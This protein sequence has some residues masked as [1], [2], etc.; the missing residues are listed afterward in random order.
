MA[1]KARC[2]VVI[3]TFNGAHLLSTCLK[4][5]FSH[6]PTTYEWQVI[7]V[8][9]ASSDGT[10]ERFS[11]YHERLTMV[12]LE[13]NQ[14]FARACNEGARVAGDAEHL[15]FLNNDTVPL[16][17]WLDALVD[18]LEANSRAAAVGAKL[19]YPDG[20]VQHAGV[21][22]GRDRWPH[23][24]Y[25]GLPGEHPAVNRAKRVV[26]ATAACLLV[27]RDA[28]ER[29]NGFDDAFLNGYEDVDFC[30]RLGEEGHEVRYC[31]RSVLYHLESVTRW[32]EDADRHDERNSRLYAERWHDRI[33]PDDFGH[34]LDDGL[35]EV[36]YGNRFPIRLSV[37]P[38]LAS[39][40]RET[41]EEGDRLELLLSARTDQIFELQAERTHAALEDL[42]DEAPLP[43]A[44]PP[45]RGSG[46]TSQT[47]HRG[48]F[49]PLVDGPGRHRVSILM[50]VMDAGDA[51]RVTLPL[52]LE[53]SAAA[54][55]ELVAVDSASR[56]HT[57][58]V[59]REF[60][61]TVI[62]ID[63][64]QFD[65]ALTRNL[66]AEQA[67]G[68][69]LLYLNQRSRPCD[70]E[71]LRPLLSALDEDPSVAG[72]SSRVLPYPDADL[73]SRR[74]GMLDPSGSAERSVKRIE[75][76]QAYAAMPVE[77]RRLLLNFH[78]VSTAIRADAFREIPFRPVRA[79]G[80]DL[81]WARAVLERGMALVHEPASRVHH[82][83][84]YSLRE[85]LM[86]NVDDGIA[87]HDVNGRSLSE[88]EAGALVRGMISSDW[89]FLRDELGLDGDEL[90]SWRL[91]ASL[92][93]AAQVAG[94]W[95]G[96][97]HSAFPADAVD[98]FSR[99]AN[100]RRRRP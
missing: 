22:I 8:D 19:L 60:D 76:R 95:L 75:D 79:I 96:A 18:E 7:V 73:L 29:L 39:V 33:G 27:E 13:R 30:L 24:L 48:E 9:D 77:K 34:Y 40:Q 11:S 67:N 1:G 4:A 90:E 32:V 43:T 25:A 98:A 10:V 50:P 20:S 23:H 62:S 44:T 64:A 66:L 5:L 88:E 51:L 41:M 35:I 17:G 74:D 71:W 63:P 28:F 16:L 15:I 89:S 52:L 56:D 2:A 93:R 83:H 21:A 92:R 36:E 81:L 46:G 3:P 94:Q 72:A 61:A 57:V 65:H 26:A 87:N 54:E 82:S 14:G 68:D 42:R 45:R 47:V 86:R 85:W 69:V 6:P 80:E 100:A 31:P 58:D 55:L 59:L 78:T 91:Q 84:E 99:V 12:A 49:R 37:S 38:L 70:K 97:N 53:Q